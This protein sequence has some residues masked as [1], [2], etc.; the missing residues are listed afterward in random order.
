LFRA[1]ATGAR[2][3]TGSNAPATPYG[4]GL[5]AELHLLAEI[6]LQPFQILKMASLDAARL[7]GAGEQLG[8]IQAGKLADMVI[9]DGDPLADISQATNIVMTIANGR[10]Y[11]LAELISPGSLPNSVGKFYN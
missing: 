4:L 2:V 6:G 7:I 11:P 8:S 3:A 5:H 9:I 10:P 1:I